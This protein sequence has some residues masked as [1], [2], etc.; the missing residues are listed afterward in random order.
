MARNKYIVPTLLTGLAG[1]GLYKLFTVKNAAETL[2]YTLGGVKI[3]YK[4][5]RLLLSIDLLITNTSNQNLSFKQFSGKLWADSN[6]LGY[7]DIPNATTIRAKADTT[8]NLSTVIPASAVVDV[9]MNN[10]LKLQLPTKGTLKGT[11]V[12]GSIN[13]PIEETFDFNT[14]AKT[15]TK[16]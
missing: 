11:A 5:F 6:F 8:V 16:K 14:P 12:I 4:N 10:L 15:A 13:L 2:R 1:F 3:S 7:V 9:L